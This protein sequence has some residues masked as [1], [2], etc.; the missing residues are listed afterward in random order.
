[1]NKKSTIVMK[2]KNPGYFFFSKYEMIHKYMNSTS[3][4]KHTGLQTFAKRDKMGGGGGTC[5][6]QTKIGKELIPH[7][8]GGGRDGG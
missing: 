5:Y 4:V 2:K 7:Q 3:N 6:P 8:R 1:M